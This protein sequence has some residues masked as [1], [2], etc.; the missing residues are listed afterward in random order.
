MILVGVLADQQF[1]PYRIRAQNRR[2][3]AAL[4][5]TGKPAINSA[6]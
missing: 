6:A 4:E 1:G 5:A 3:E 2:R